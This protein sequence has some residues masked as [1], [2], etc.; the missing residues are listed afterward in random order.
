M[1]RPKTCM[2]QPNSRNQGLSVDCVAEAARYIIW[3]RLRSRKL[4]RL[5]VS[6][7]LAGFSA[8]D[9]SLLQESSI[10]SVVQRQV[11][12]ATS[13]LFKKR[14]TGG[15]DD[16]SPSK[17]VEN[18]TT[19]ATT[20]FVPSDPTAIKVEPPTVVV[21]YPA[22]FWLD[23][24]GAL[25]RVSYAAHG[26][27]SSA[28]LWSVLDR[29]YRPNLSLDEAVALLRECLQQLQARSMIASSQF[30]VKCLDATGRCRVIS[31]EEETR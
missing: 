30:C 7:L 2:V 3:Q 31:L 14:N 10:E 6:L 8:N 12:L 24:Y 19:E 27:M 21:H 1:Y 15:T 29:G 20:E 25:Q 23:E 18:G 16:S 17:T 13:S 11:S 22:L 5:Q 26:G 9:E 28:L 4:P